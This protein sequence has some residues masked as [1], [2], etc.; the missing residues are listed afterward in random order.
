MP[1]P[2]NSRS[3]TRPKR[4]HVSTKVTPDKAN[5]DYQST[6]K[7]AAEGKQ[8]HRKSEETRNNYR[9]HIRRGVE[10]L[11]DFVKE[12]QAAEENWK[13]AENGS[14][15]LSADD[16]NEIPTDDEAQMDPHFHL[17]FTGPPIRCTST[18]I[19]MFMAHK[20]FTEEHGKSTASAVHAAFLDHY[21]QL[22]GDKYRG[23]WRY[24]EVNKE[25]V[26]NPV[27]SA[28][29]ED[30]LEACKNKDGESERRHSR[31]ISIEDMKKLHDNSR[32]NC[33][34][35]F[36]SVSTSCDGRKSETEAMKKRVMYLLFNALSTTAFIIWMREA[37]TLQY[38]HLEFLHGRRREGFFVKNPQ[39]HFF[40][41]NLRNRKNWQKRVRNGEQQLNGHTYN[42][43]PQNEPSID[44]YTHL[45]DWLDLYEVL[46]GRPLEPD[47]YIFPTIG[48]GGVLH[49]KRLMSSDIAQKRITAMAKEAGVHGA[50]YFTTHCFQRG[51][52]QYRFMFAEPGQRWTLARIR[53]WG[54]WAQ[55][56]HRDTLIKYLLDEL[57]TYE[58]DHCDTLN[59]MDSLDSVARRRLDELQ[60]QNELNQK[61]I[62][63]KYQ[64]YHAQLH[65]QHDELVSHVNNLLHSVQGNGES[66]HH[67]HISVQPFHR[68][69][70]YSSSR[71]L[72]GPGPPHEHLLDGCPRYNTGSPPPHCQDLSCPYHL[73][74]SIPPLSIP[75][76][77]PTL[78]QN[79]RGPGNHGHS[80][81][82]STRPTKHFVPELGRNLRKRAWEQI[83]KDWEH[84]DPSRSLFVAMKNWDST[85]FKSKAEEVKFGQ[86]Q[87]IA[88]EFIDT[89]NRDKDRFLQDYPEGNV[90]FSALLKAIRARRQENGECQLR[91]KRA[92]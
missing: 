29:V 12:E 39:K 65:L 69:H 2:S 13:N 42:L 44:A 81:A 64:V 85:F 88:V 57:Y 35:A 8:K 86:R 11:A 17:A 54:G 83:V 45:L 59:P 75:H 40:K 7:V 38:K 6:F 37:T 36:P 78:E 53:W 33:P 28:V 1:G 14:N 67:S 77:H 22:E 23:R 79:Q 48:A 24:D 18:A 49:P 80:G 34:P 51:G 46:I 56:E 62:E 25:W 73:D 16:E 87:M 74:A 43:Y 60:L 52:A 63:E 84:P 47:D 61:R 92:G 90:S 55:G 10:F 58:G 82:N 70:P 72:T 9:G 91:R 71:A 66:P 4:K 31:A 3:K 26:G 5:A 21:A 32:K 19:M 50:E 89:Y 41:V 30:M 76:S 27:R 20:C 15:H 68:Y